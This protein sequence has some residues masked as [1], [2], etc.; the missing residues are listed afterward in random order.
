ML[1]V[2]VDSIESLLYIVPCQRRAAFLR[3]NMAGM[4]NETLYNILVISAS[5]I[6][7]FSALFY[8]LKHITHIPY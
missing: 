5:N 7:Q 2:V 8:K 4:S 6:D 3:L 1:Q